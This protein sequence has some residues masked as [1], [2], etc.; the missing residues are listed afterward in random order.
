MIRS[1]LYNKKL[2]FYHVTY[3]GH[4]VVVLLLLPAFSSSDR[5]SNVFRGGVLHSNSKNDRINTQVRQ[6]ILVIV[7]ILVHYF[8][9]YVSIMTVSRVFGLVCQL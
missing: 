2:S 6:Q 8:Y 3:C 9:M 4:F 1:F 5:N 7:L